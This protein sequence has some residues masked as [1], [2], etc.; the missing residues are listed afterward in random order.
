MLA[1][2]LLTIAAVA[3]F[4]IARSIYL[5]FQ[6]ILPNRPASWVGLSNYSTILHDPSFIEAITTTALFTISSAA[7][8]FAVGVA[9]AVILNRAFAGRGLVRAIILLPWAFP[10]VVTAVMFRLLLNDQTGVINHVANAA[11]VVDGPMLLDRASL[12]VSAI[13]VDVWKTT[14]FMALLVLPAFAAVPREIIEAARVDGAGAWERFRYIV[15]PL[16][17]PVLL[18]ALLF[19][20]LDAMRVYDL[21]WVMTARELESLSTYVYKGV[22]ISQ[23]RFSEGN[24]AAVIA[25]FIA[26]V[27]TVA[28]AR[29]V[30]SSSGQ[31]ETF[32]P[33]GTGPRRVRT[34]ARRLFFYAGITLLLLFTTGPLF[35]IAKMSLAS[36]VDIAASP[37]TLLPQT[38]TLD[39]FSAV[40]QDGRFRQGIYSSLSIGLATTVI[41]VVLGS[42]AAYALARLH[43]RGSTVVL[44]LMLGIGFFPPVAI[45]VP[46]FLFLSE[47]GLI[48][49]YW[50]MIIPDTVFALPL[51]TWLLATFFRELPEHVEE[52]AQ[53]DG[54][55]PLQVLRKVVIPLGAPGVFTAAVITF[56]LT[57]NE[58]L[59]A[60]TFTFS[61]DIKP[62]TVV[63]AD[64]AGSAVPDV[65][66]AAAA[67]VVLTLPVA[68][69]V[70]LFQRRIVSGLSA[71]FVRE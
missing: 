39:N 38:F 69:L 25:F 23:L 18:V 11:G 64:Y 21:F 43:L 31:A 13:L 70:L 1:P 17:K 19:R 36:P 8:S 27:L 3:L 54:A 63:I 20:V 34:P 4:P 24:A 44:T 29:G 47:T 33:V 37:P 45:L 48:D 68:L 61:P 49:T 71:G 7:L 12:M 6:R 26:L 2:A 5:G 60:N 57:W 16:A 55:T 58:Y 22:L 56:V 10:A 35:L 46:L 28:F 65:G 14:P 62:A 9:L 50:A 40:L 66:S 59:F 15:L 30:L 53:M 52:A 32:E 67:A 42:L 41:C 51:A